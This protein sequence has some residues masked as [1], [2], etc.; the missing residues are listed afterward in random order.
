MLLPLRSSRPPLLS[1]KGAT[2]LGF[3]PR[4]P[5]QTAP[6]GAARARP[7]GVKEGGWDGAWDAG[8]YAVPAGDAQV[9]GAVAALFAR[10]GRTGFFGDHYLGQQLVR[11][12][13]PHGDLE[14]QLVPQR[15]SYSHT[16]APAAGTCSGAGPCSCP[17]C[18]PAQP[19]Q[20]AVEWRGWHVLINRF[21]Y[22]PPGTPHLVIAKQGHA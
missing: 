2:T 6:S 17:F 5:E 16:P 10:A 14:A 15:A 12:L 9:G 21:P 8:A 4:R 1:P 22:T 20:K 7:A 18:N 13:G 11:G 3:V 19:G